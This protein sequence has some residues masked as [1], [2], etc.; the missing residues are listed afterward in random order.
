MT[1]ASVILRPV[2]FILD[3]V[4]RVDRRTF[5]TGGTFDRVARRAFP[6]DRDPLDDVD[7]SALETA[8]DRHPRSSPA[9]LRPFD[10]QVEHA[11]PVDGWS[12]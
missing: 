6:F 12:T 9:R 8:A 4:P 3:P 11:W 10:W 5:V 2:S 1:A 7:W